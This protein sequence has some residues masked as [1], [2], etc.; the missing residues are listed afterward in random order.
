MNV[1]LFVFLSFFSSEKTLHKS[2][3]E[4]RTHCERTPPPPPPRFFS[5]SSSKRREEEEEEEEEEDHLRV[6][7]SI[8]QYIYRALENV[9]CTIGFLKFHISLLFWILKSLLRVQIISLSLSRRPIE[10]DASGGDLYR[11]FQKHGFERNQHTYI[12]T[13]IYTYLSVFR[14]NK[15]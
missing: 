5:S 11:V 12:Y 8:A 2:D 14:K 6:F 1:P 13:H 7:V 9:V 15:E 3:A 4:R 10:N